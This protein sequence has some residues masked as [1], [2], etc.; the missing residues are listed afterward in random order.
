MPELL[1]AA[2]RLAAIV[3]SSDDAI[4]SKSLEGIIMSW[5]RGAERIFGYRAD[6][7][8]GKSITTI[9]PPDRLSEE[10][11]VMS[12]IR[13]GQPVE[14][15]ET[16]RLRS[17]G[18]LVPISLT[19]SPIRDADGRVIGA[20]KIARDI[21]D[22][23]RAE[24]ALEAAEAR[25]KDLQERLI[26]LVAASGT[27]FLSPRVD[28]VTP[29]ILAVAK[30]LIP[31]DGYAVWRYD[32]TRAA[33][34][35]AASEGISERFQQSIVD[36]YGGE[37]V[38]P[39][40][41]T[42]PL[43]AES[44]ATIPMLAERAA[45]HRAE[46]IESMLAV[47][48]MIGGTGSGTLVFYYFTRH[49]FSEVEVQTARA[50]SNLASAAIATAELYDDQ[51]RMRED[52][53]RAN[54]QA[55]FLSEVSAALVSSLDYEATLR[56]L[57]N[58]AV[59]PFADFC[60]VD[61]VNEGGV[62]H[63]LAM[64][65][66]NPARLEVARSFQERYPEDPAPGSIGHVVRTGTPIMVTHLTD[67]MLT[68]AAR[69]KEH[70]GALRE[71]AV[72]SY[73]TVPLTAHGRTFGALTFAY[74]ESG[75]HYGEADFRFAKDVGY[76][77]A[78]A[79]ENA[80]AYRQATAANRAKDEFLATLSHELRTPLNAVLGWARMLRAGTLSASKLPRAFDVI[81]R[82]AAAQLDLVEDLLDMSRIITGKF[83]LD[84]VPIDLAAVI[85]AA[86]EAIQPAATAK[87]IA[88]TVDVEESYCTVLGDSARLQQVVWNLLSNAIKFTP[89]GGR[90]RI[91]LKQTEGSQVEV[92]VSDSGEGIEP[93]VLPFV[94]DRFRQGETGTT[95]THMGL[96]LGL[97]IVRH[98]VE[99]H[100][101]RVD[102][103]SA[104][105]G[106][107]ATF[108]FILPASAVEPRAIAAADAEE[109]RAPRRL[110]GRML[111]GLHALVVDDDR[112]ARDLL[113]EV[114]RSRGMEVTTA[115]SAAEGLAALD[116]NV[117]DIILSDIAMPNLD[118]L[119]MMRRV[120]ERSAAR[121][122]DVPAVALTAYARP[123]D[124]ERSRAS[125]FQ[126]HLSKPVDADRLISTVVALAGRVS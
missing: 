19:V 76:R 24:A 55:A 97:A 124:S 84:V 83:R 4:V 58:L 11:H 62:S 33:W 54:R 12:R 75:R 64:A 122:G 79:V 86:V 82:N 92:E 123:E 109:Y 125:G 20:S 23:R 16:L 50:L 81:E 85:E 28:N 100:G 71:L 68:A 69:D 89:R 17:D 56:T 25:R 98:I 3:E 77:A 21:S 42:E 118:G 96:G 40:P 113:C 38:S 7:I 34:W 121:G 26:A 103:V 36:S 74:A 115:A 102:A 110:P 107:G 5:N 111:T 72:V 60:A 46:G 112:D 6:E 61:I 39:V 126:V 117:P 47:P 15:Y 57:A 44:V 53:E 35:I 119:E 67:D 10:T 88:V 90:V 59:P 22:R 37:A 101:G 8:I 13:A 106:L 65:H 99:L 108:R 80:R 41:F 48:L 94:F 2:L 78:L 27:L 51:R 63:R 49:L 104:G 18:V 45:A 105:K 30:P 1:A 91:A 31:A 43:V 116:H 66:V 29:A 120:R 32:A 87:G 14:H 70:L 114:L 9:I 95:R 73:I 93:D 52:A